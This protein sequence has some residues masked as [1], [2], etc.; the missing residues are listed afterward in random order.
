[1]I[2]LIASDMDGTLLN[3]KKQ[4]PQ[5]LT[6]V[7][8]RLG[9]RGIHFAISSGRTYFAID[10]L[11][12]SE[13]LDRMDFICDNGACVISGGKTLSVSALDRE[14]FTELL[15]ACDRI[16][17]LK[18]LVCASK[19]TYH[20]E[21]SPAFTSE[22]AKFYKHHFPVEELRAV[23]DVIYKLAIYDE[24]GTLSHGKPAIDAIFGTRL[25]VQASGPYWMDVM[26]SGVSKGSALAALQNTLGV[27]RAETMAF[28]DYFNDISMLERAEWNFCME[29]GHDDVKKLCRFVA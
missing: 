19:G 27:T 20:L 25:N 17:G 22:I 9:E 14:T 7:L 13:Y 15:D 26:A 8:D 11:F 12:P 23:Q 24:A 28:G 2:K 4:L 29:N 18:V 16:G 3:D 10:H 1:M 6:E 5:D 21:D